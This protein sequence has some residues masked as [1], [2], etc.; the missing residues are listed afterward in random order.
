MLIRS[1][2]STAFRSSIAESN[3][4]VAS[5]TCS[6]VSAPTTMAP[7]AARTLI[8]SSSR[9][10]ERMP[11][12]L[13]ATWTGTVKPCGAADRPHAHPD[14]PGDREPDLGE[15]A[16]NLA[17]ASFGHHDADGPSVTRG[18]HH[19]GALRFREAVLQ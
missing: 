15:H 9:S 5:N 19:A 12:R 14:Q 10:P 18:R 16:S 1:P 13:Q 7:R 2:V 17:L 8:R 11:R 4:C 6:E 3:R